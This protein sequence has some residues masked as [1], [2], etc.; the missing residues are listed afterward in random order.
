MGNP[1]GFTEFR[2]KM[3]AKRS[4]G[5]RVGDWREIYLNWDEKESRSQASRCM[6]CGVPFCNKGCPLGNLIPEFNDLV[7]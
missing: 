1:F 2:R 6:D 4:S 7:Y 5:T 3:P